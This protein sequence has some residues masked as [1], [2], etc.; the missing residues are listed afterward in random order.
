MEIHL[1][2]TLRM[3]RRRKN[4]TQET[5]AHYLGITPQSVGKWER[6]EGFPD[7]TMLP[8]MALY[9]D[10]T[11]DELLDVGQARI[12]KVIMDYK[13]ESAGYRNAGETEK[14]I[15][16]WEKAYKE[17]PNDCRVMAEL[18]SA[19]SMFFLGEG[20]SRER[21]ERIIMLGERILQ[22]S[23]DMELRESAVQ[24]LCYTYK[25]MGDDTNAI[26]YAEMGGSFYTT[27][28]EL[29]SFVQEGEDG[30]RAC[31]SYILLLV[32]AA[33]RTAAYGLVGKGNYTAEEEICIFEFCISL[34]KLLFSDD[35]T[36]F[37]ANDISQYYSLLSLSHA[38]AEDAE[39]TLEAL[40]NAAKY[41]LAA[42]EEREGAY[43]APLVNHLRNDPTKRTQNYRGN[44]CN[45]RLDELKRKEY[46]FLR[47]DKRFMELEK[48]LQGKAQF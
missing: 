17:F 26:H 36:G 14:D 15:A 33:A 43:T 35:N 30:V 10:V 44:A 27:R 32:A 47:E 5:L 18:M 20:G 25:S 11:V 24:S 41:A 13:A 23:G 31:Q 2:D 42:A 8:K 3:L 1:K 4:I 7:I 40:K 21:A 29:L 38:A 48:E 34:M 39:K 12:D 37:Y 28:E 9:F 22:A 45:L 19:L 46:D 16:L 6:G